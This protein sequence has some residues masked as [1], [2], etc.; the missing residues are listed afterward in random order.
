MENSTQQTWLT[1]NVA[2]WFTIP[3]NSTSCDTGS[4]QSYGNSAAQAAGF[5]LSN[6]QRF[7]YLMSGNS[8]CSWWGYAYIGG[9]VVWVNG[10]YGF[11]VHV[12]SH[13]MGHNFGLYHS[14]TVNCGTQVI[15][16]NGTFNEYGDPFDVMGQPSYNPPHYNAFQKERLGWLNSGSQPPI[17]TITSSGTYQIGAY[18]AQ[19]ST[20]KALKV[21]Q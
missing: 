20:P 3:V 14:H 19:D 13:E 18:E 6:Y 11:D 1:G 10:K 21:Q 8:G 7:I 15:C 9:S 16:S 17:L 5:N 4:V 2:G 12:V